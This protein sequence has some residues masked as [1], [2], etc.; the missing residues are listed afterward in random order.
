MA[1]APRLLWHLW[2]GSARGAVQAACLWLAW[3]GSAAAAGGVIASA[4]YTEP[5]TRYAH[6]VLGDAIEWGALELTL[7]SGE[8]VTFTLPQDHVFEDVAPRLHDVDGDGA[9][10][11]VVVEADVTAGAALAIYGA[12][13]KITETPHIGTRNRWLAPL[14]AADLDGDGAV[15]L[16]YIDRPHLA[17]TLRIWRYADGALTEVA[18]LPGLTNHR[19]GEA[20]IAGG[21]RTCGAEPEMLLATANWSELVVVTWGATGFTWRPLGRDTSRAAFADA[22]ACR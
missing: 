2:H 10:E 12:G 8:T 6:A 3:S 21:I 5:T 18:A 15:E 16:A 7:D 17:K 4:Q 14:G 9:P 22:M 11:V 1:G 19:I 13:G 20:D